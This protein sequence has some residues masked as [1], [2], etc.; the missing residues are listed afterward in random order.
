MCA[1]MEEAAAPAVF[2]AKV[3]VTSINPFLPGLIMRVPGKK[4][5]ERN[6]YCGRRIH[7][8]N[9]TFLVSLETVERRIEY[10]IFFAYILLL[11]LLSRTHIQ[12]TKRIS[13]T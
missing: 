8:A 11:F 13:P 6:F 4:R 5:G 9:I 3:E 10:K 1:L 7:F 2:A 12:E